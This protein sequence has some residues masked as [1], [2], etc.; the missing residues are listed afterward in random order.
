M[1]GRRDPIHESIKSV[2]R[3]EQLSAFPSTWQ[4]GVSRGR[5]CLGHTDLGCRGSAG[6]NPFLKIPSSVRQGHNSSKV[7]PR[8]LCT[9][10]L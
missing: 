7:D 2:G 6:I 4:A 10:E 1:A 8:L 5:R 3:G 9:S